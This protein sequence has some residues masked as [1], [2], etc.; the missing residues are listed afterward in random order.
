MSFPD[1]QLEPRPRARC[2]HW[3]QALNHG[4]DAVYIGGPDSG[5]ARAAA[6]ND[7]RDISA[8]CGTRTYAL[9]LRHPQHHLR[10]GKARNP[11]RRMAWQLYPRQVS[12]PSSSG[13]GLLEI[14]MPP[15]QLMPADRHPHAEG[16]L[17]H[18]TPACRRSLTCSRNCDA[19]ADAANPRRPP[20]QALRDRVL[21]P[22]RALCVAYSSQ[23]YISRHTHT[24][25]APIGAT[26]RRPAACRIT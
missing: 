18:G 6:S 2:R 4:A 23:C 8:W 22:R 21:H 7:I 15:I 10:D 19:A 17:P 9:H 24:G 14:D 3:H 5:G 1:H 16:P 25:A 26:A 11:A 13:H 20:I 12:T